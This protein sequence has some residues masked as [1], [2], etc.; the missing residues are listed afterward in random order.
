MSTSCSRS[1]AYAEAVLTEPAD[2]SG[3]SDLAFAPI[4]VRALTPY[5]DAAPVELFERADPLRARAE[6]SRTALGTLGL[7]ERDIAALADQAERAMRATT[8][9]DGAT[10]QVQLIDSIAE[11]VPRDQ[12]VA[13]AAA[14]AAS[15]GDQDAGALLN[16]GFVPTDV[17][18]ANGY[19]C[20]LDEG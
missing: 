8:P 3:L 4:L 11:T 12:V 13:A 20:L 16:L 14:L 15:F 2:E 19:G 5:L 7:T 17:A 1:T 18:T 6:L 9:T 10:I